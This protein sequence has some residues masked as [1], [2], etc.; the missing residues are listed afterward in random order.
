MH[1][2]NK[3]QP[4]KA[5]QASPAFWQIGESYNKN[6]QKCKTF[7]FIIDMIAYITEIFVDLWVNKVKNRKK[8]Y[9]F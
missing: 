4:D 6:V 8:K 3:P 1:I 7:G 9:H 5:G 2:P